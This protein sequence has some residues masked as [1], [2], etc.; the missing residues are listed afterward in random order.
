MTFPWNRQAL[1]VRKQEPA[2]EERLQIVVG[3]SYPSMFGY[4]PTT[5]TVTRMVN[6]NGDV[7]VHYVWPSSMGL[8]PRGD[9]L[10]TFCRDIARRM[11]YENNTVQSVDVTEYFRKYG[12]AAGSEGELG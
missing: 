7:T 11:A 2:T 6:F 9:S 4:T 12:L 8:Q 1:T 5:L 3:A 10:E